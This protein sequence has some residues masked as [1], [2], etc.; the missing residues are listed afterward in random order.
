MD[1][2][3]WVDTHDTPTFL[4]WGP[5]A[6]QAGGLLGKKASTGP[7]RHIPVKSAYRRGERLRT[8][9]R[10]TWSFGLDRLKKDLSS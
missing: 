8:S 6:W 7:S 9:S 4:I 5:P 2:V 10:H 1:T 3:E